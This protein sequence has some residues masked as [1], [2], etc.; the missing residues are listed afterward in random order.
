[1]CTKYCYHTIDENAGDQGEG[2]VPV[3]AGVVYWFPMARRDFTP[4]RL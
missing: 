2:Y 4:G 3:E 1:M